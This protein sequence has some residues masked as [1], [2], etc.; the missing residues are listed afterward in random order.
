MKLFSKIAVKQSN[1]SYY[2]GLLLSL[3]LVL[4]AQFLKHNGSMSILNTI[5]SNTGPHKVGIKTHTVDTNTP[6]FLAN[7]DI[8]NGEIKL[9][10]SNDTI[11]FL[12]NKIP[13][14]A[15]SSGLYH[16]PLTPAEQLFENVNNSIEHDLI[17]LR[18]T[19]NKSNKEIALKLHCSFTYPPAEKLLKLINNS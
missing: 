1:K 18:T 5:P 17:V 10:F 4:V 16:L 15:T 13:L 3:T 6:L 14:N 9:K 8:K 11:N 2:L 7:S 19:K 12:R